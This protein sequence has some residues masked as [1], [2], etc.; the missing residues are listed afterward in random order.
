M[1][2]GKPP[3]GEVAGVVI[4][5]EVEGGQC[6]NYCDSDGGLDC[7]WKGTLAGKQAEAKGEEVFGTGLACWVVRTNG[8]SFSSYLARHL[9][10]LGH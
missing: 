8:E 6:S 2:T 10:R 9:T 4:E 5:V 3:P 1:G 7:A